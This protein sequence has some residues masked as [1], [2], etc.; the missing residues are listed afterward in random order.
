V[1]IADNTRISFFM[2][3][4]KDIR[5]QY[6]VKQAFDYSC[7]AAALATLLT[8][9]LNDPV[10]EKD[11]IAA[12]LTALTS[13]EEQLRQKEGFSLLDMQRVAQQRGYL[14]QGFRI[15]P[16]FLDDLK[17]PVIVFITPRGYEHFAVLRGISQ[18]DA[19]L[20]DPSRGNIREPL[21]TFLDTWLGDD[22]KGVVFV[23]EPKGGPIATTLLD[24][25]A[26]EIPRPDLVGVRHLLYSGL[27]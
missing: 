9:G 20:A 6:L 14:A 12:M 2:Q 25:G 13:D 10:S 23:I 1:E 26:S 7:G 4:F 8:Y 11:M 27:L 18:G 3:S 5:D 17:G 21:V 19:Y 15:A 24:L 16:R 22:G